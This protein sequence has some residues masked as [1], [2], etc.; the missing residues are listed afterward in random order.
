MGVFD[1]KIKQKNELDD[2]VIEESFRKL[3]GVITRKQAFMDPASERQNLIYC[4][5]EIGRRLHVTIPYSSRED[6]TISWYQEKYFRPQGIMW[7][8]VSLKGTWYQDAIG[9]MLGSF[10]D[11]RP[12]VFKPAGNGR[13]HYLDPVTDK[14]IK[15]SQY[16]AGLF[17]PEATLYYKTLPLRKI[18]M[19]DIWKFIR[20]SITVKEVIKLIIATLSMMVLSMITPAMTQLLMSSVVKTSDLHLLTVILVILIIVT[21]ALFFVTV[22][23]QFLLAAISTSVAVPLQSAFMMR[24]LTA[25]ADELKYFSAGDLGARIGAMYNQ[26]KQMV[27]MFLSLIL[28][29]ACSLI[30][31][32]QMFHFAPGLACVAVAVTV[33]LAALLAYVIKKQSKISAD[34]MNY[35]AEKSGLTYSFIDGMEKISLTGAQK[36]AFAKWTG[37]YQKAV[38]TIYDPPL[39]LKIYNV[40]IPAILLVG[41]IVMYSVAMEAEVSKADFFAFLS[42][43]GILTAAMTTIGNSIGDFASALPVFRTLKPVMEFVPEIS[44]E[45]QV[46]ES[47]NGRI[48][49]QNITFSYTKQMPPVLENLSL[50]INQGEYVAIVGMTGCGKSTITRLMLGFEKPDF[51]FILYDGKELGSLDITSLRRNIGV[52]LQNGDIF[53]GTIFSNIVISGTN[54]SEEDAWEAAEIAG[55]ADDIRRMPMQMNT[56]VPDG[57]RGISGGQKQRLLIARAI[58]SKPSILIFDEATS[59]LDNITQ[60]AVSDALG[61][62]NCTRIVIAHR[63]STVQNCDRILVLDGG[64][65][66]EEGT[67]EELMKQ[68]GLFVKLVKKQQI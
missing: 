38:Q 11:G 67:Y 25:P 54:L 30:C 36:R 64:R 21:A 59:A 16:N 44:G 57:G 6:L 65:I 23:R 28:T 49:L 63:L 48:T 2:D 68:N 47:L 8:E 14:W 58:V 20:E 46:V 5:E 3:A 42:S 26:L 13:Y 56:M 4:I 40:L 37:V 17:H 62:L 29:A 32:I 27:N 19:R 1:E 51:G 55:I 10:T 45:K 33:I 34:M 39:I 18:T 12:V 31:F 61:E 66:A 22:I 41:T 53:R 43:Y 60:K 24:I 35:Q 50:D 9:V 52:V 7:R 15:I